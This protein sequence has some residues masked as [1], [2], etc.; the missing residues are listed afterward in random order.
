MPLIILFYKVPKC[1]VVCMNVL[2]TV[3]M[4]AKVREECK[5]RSVMVF[6]DEI[7]NIRTAGN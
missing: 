5:A 3:R 2:G 4:K 7:E 1:E 6:K